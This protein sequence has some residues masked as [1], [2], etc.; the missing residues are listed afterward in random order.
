VKA[1]ND[2]GSRFPATV[3]AA[4]A[5]WEAAEC[6]KTMGDTA[7]ARELYVALRSFSS[8]RDRAE[9][10]LGDDS[11]N[12]NMGGAQVASKSASGGYIPK[13]AAPAP[14][15]VAAAPAGKAKA[16]MEAPAA[17][18]KPTG[19]VPSNAKAAPMRAADT[20]AGY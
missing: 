17:S 6:Y 10:E 20:A 8:Y 18:Q 1:Y 9:Q 13:N 3:S 11:S 2:V 5:M 7:K 4:D 16:V 14:A 12:S 19:A 15:A